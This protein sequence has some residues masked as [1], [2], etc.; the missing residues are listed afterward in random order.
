MEVLTVTAPGAGNEWSQ[1][2]TAGQ[3]WE[4]QTIRFRFVTDATVTNRTPRIFVN[5]GANTYFQ[6]SGATNQAASLTIDYA[7][8]NVGSAY[9][10][11]DNITRIASLPPLLVTGDEVITTNTTNRQAGDAFSNIVLSYRLVP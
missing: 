2:V 4:L 11:T 9:A 1:T 7:F 3:I 8:S 10:P 5:N 6:V